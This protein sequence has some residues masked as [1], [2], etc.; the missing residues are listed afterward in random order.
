MDDAT[1]GPDELRSFYERYIAAFN[2][3]NEQAFLGCFNLPVSV[4]RLPAGGMDP[5]AAPLGGVT[6]PDALWPALPSKWT[7]STIDD[8]RVVADDAF[9]PRSGFVERSPRRAALEVTVTRWAGES[10]YEQIH[11]LYLLT[12]EAGHLGIKAMVPLA[13][14]RPVS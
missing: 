6:A 11:V 2:D 10:P 14:A 9:V 13:I 8:I 1:P 12:S 3:R 5:V 7:R 4:L